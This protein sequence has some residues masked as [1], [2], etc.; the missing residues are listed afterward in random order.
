M[1]LHYAVAIRSMKER[2]GNLARN[3]GDDM[4]AIILLACDVSEFLLLCSI[5]AWDVDS[6]LLGISSDI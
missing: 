6:M 4:T 3:T 5:C 1:R 2:I